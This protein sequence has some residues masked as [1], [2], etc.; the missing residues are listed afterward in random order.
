MGRTFEALERAE[1]EYQDNL[2]KIPDDSQ[3]TAVTK[4]SGKFPMQT[5]SDRFQEVKKKIITQFSEAPNIIMKSKAPLF[6]LLAG[7]ISSLLLFFI[8]YYI[9]WHF[10]QYKKYTSDSPNMEIVVVMVG[11]TVLYLFLY[12][13]IW[14]TEF[15]QTPWKSFLLVS[16]I[17]VLSFFIIPTGYFARY[18]FTKAMDKIAAKQERV[19]DMEVKL[20]NVIAL[21]VTANKS[22]MELQ[23]KLESARKENDRLRTELSEIK[24]KP[25]PIEIGSK[26][27]E[28]VIVLANS[29]KN[30]SRIEKDSQAGMTDF[31]Q[32]TEEI[33][34]R[35]QIISSNTRLAINSPEF[36]GIKNVS[37]Y[38][39][40]GQYKYTVGNQKDLTSAI[41]LQSEC[42]KKGFSGAF[43]VAFKNGKRIPVREA[44]KLLK[45]SVFKNSFSRSSRR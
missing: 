16:I 41:S 29:N 26:T 10:P 31:D 19:K 27:K 11:I 42:R 25:N 7:Y 8:W 38:E 34:F 15:F 39:D 33:L 9:I 21:N 13:L 17:T 45:Q 24:R 1:K 4:R 5:P 36:K 44:L 28:D 43:V 23:A 35:A 37:E 2:L 22:V 32:K 20:K 18:E 6:L 12:F 3:K 14:R 40:N 30:L